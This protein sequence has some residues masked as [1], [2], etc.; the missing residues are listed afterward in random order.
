MKLRK[1]LYENF[2]QPFV[3]KF[4]R[5]LQFPWFTYSS[6]L[7][8]ET[9]IHRVQCVFV[10]YYF[11]PQ[12]PLYEAQYLIIEFCSRLNDSPNFRISLR[13]NFYLGAD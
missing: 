8:Y 5:N 3:N 6:Y 7:S 11:W 2:L 4:E 12:N 13:G 10:P 1:L 9:F